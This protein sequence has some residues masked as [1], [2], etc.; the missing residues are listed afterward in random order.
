MEV[1]RIFVRVHLFYIRSGHMD[2]YPN[3][4]SS[5]QFAPRS[6][7]IASIGSPSSLGF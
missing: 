6:R 7:I 2:A 5:L 3:T 4:L 1:L